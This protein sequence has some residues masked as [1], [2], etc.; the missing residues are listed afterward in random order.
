MNNTENFLIIYL[1]PETDVLQYGFKK[2]VF[3]WAG[4]EFP[5]GTFE[6]TFNNL[7]TVCLNETNYPRKHT[8]VNNLLPSIMNPE[9]WVRLDMDPHTIGEMD[10]LVFSDN[11]CSDKNIVVNFFREILR[12]NSFWIVVYIIDESPYYLVSCAIEQLKDFLKKALEAEKSVVIFSPRLLE[13]CINSPGEE[14]INE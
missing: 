4:E 5:Q 12:D 14:F 13:E 1:P 9:T 6:F 3:E 8:L 10:N 2:P 11:A 7:L